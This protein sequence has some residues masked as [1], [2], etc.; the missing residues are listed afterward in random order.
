VIHVKGAATIAAPFSEGSTMTA[1]LFKP[2]VAVLAAWMGLSAG[3]V[4]LSP[5]ETVTVFEAAGLQLR[6]GGFAIEGCASALKPQAEPVVLETG[7]PA[8]VLV[9]L[10]RSACFAESQSGHV[11]LLVKGD[12]GRWA[13]RMAFVP[14]V[15]VVRQPT[16]NLS[17]PDL[18]VAN[19]GGCMPLYRYDGSRYQRHAQKALQPGG[20]QFRE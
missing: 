14:G 7:K 5:A 18:G 15:E 12:D 2:A 10:G 13:M 3:A 9:Y 4:N 16:S 11:A 19:P 1:S 20:C 17:W 6:D 8:G